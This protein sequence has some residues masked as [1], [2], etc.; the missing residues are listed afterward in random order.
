LEASPGN[1]EAQSGT[2]GQFAVQCYILVSMATGIASE[3][4][5]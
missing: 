1:R 2:R 4:P 5:G 3:A